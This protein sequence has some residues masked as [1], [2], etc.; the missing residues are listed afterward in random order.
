MIRN[1][2]QKKDEAGGD[3][4]RV[5]GHGVAVESE[6]GSI[7]IARYAVTYPLSNQFLRSGC[8]NGSW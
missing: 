5:I 8:W 3:L 4:H 1:L 6:V 2:G 7:R